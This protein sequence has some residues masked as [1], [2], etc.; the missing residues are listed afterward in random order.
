MKVDKSK[1]SIEKVIY[2]SL[3]IVLTSA[4][5]MLALFNIPVADDYWYAYH[6]RNTS[7]W[8]MVL[9][10]YHNWTGRLLP[11]AMLALGIK[12][13]EFFYPLNILLVLMFMSTPVLLFLFIRRQG[14]FTHQLFSLFV[15]QVFFLLGFRD[16]LAENVYWVTGGVMYIFCLFMVLVWLYFYSRF[17]SSGRIFYFLIA[18]S[19]APFIGLTH[20][21]LTAAVLIAVVLLFNQAFQQKSITG[22]VKM[23]LFKMSI[24]LILLIAGFVVLSTAPGNFQRATLLEDSPISI[25]EMLVNW[26]DKFKKLFYLYGKNTLAFA[27]I[28]GTILAVFDTKSTPHAKK[29]RN[30]LLTAFVFFISAALTL[31]PLARYPLVEGY[32][33][34]FFGSFFMFL[35]VALFLF[36]GISFL[37]DIFK[38]LTPFGNNLKGLHL[39]SFTAKWFFI[40]ILTVYVGLI[41]QTQYQRAIPF[42]KEYVEGRKEFLKNIATTFPD[43]VLVKMPA[44]RSASPTWFYFHDLTSDTQHYINKAHVLFW[45]LGDRK[46]IIEEPIN[47]Q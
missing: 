30:L 9:G 43:S 8:N 10:E 4:V 1:M 14:Y 29:Q 18:T 17:L 20:E 11:S 26:F 35:A 15:L 3:I 28:T 33:V 16:F 23:S 39:L 2:L 21:Q 34:F 37:I 13:L 40:V 5:V 12:E 31:L 32:R 47:A 22:N 46:I 45:R 38:M 6:L 25:S 27:I 7:V 41:I 24:P 42:K 44:F 36:A 19:L